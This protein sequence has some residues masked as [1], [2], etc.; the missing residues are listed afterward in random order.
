VTCIH[1][2]GAHNVRASALRNA[3]A[4]LLVAALSSVSASACADARSAPSDEADRVYRVFRE[5]R[6]ALA[7]QQWHAAAASFSSELLSG[8]VA[9]M[10]SAGTEREAVVARNSAWATITGGDVVTAVCSYRVER[11]G[12]GQARL[13][14]AVPRKTSDGVREV[15]VR[16][17]HEG[18]AWRISGFDFRGPVG[19]AHAC[20]A[21]LDTFP[22]ATPNSAQL[23]VP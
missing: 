3:G 8:L 17:V 21:P 20:D 14:L 16:F 6:E 1:V 9:E 22:A 10:V 11:Q 15:V 23:P 7:T 19:A 12:S 5:Y 4:L 2:S 13:H 18:G